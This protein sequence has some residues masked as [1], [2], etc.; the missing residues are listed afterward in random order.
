M[1]FLSGC[2]GSTANTAGKIVSP[3]N[4]LMPIEGKWVIEKGLNSNFTVMGNEV[5]NKWIGKYVQFSH[6]A[7][8]L[9]N[10]LFRQ[11][12]YKI[13]R[14]N[15]DEYLLYRHK[16]PGEKYGIK[17]NKIYVITIAVKNLYSFDAVLTDDG[18]LIIE[19]DDSILYLKKLSDNVDS[20]LINKCNKYNGNNTVGAPAKELPSH[21]GLVLGLKYAGNDNKGELEYKY[22]TI[23]IGAEVKKLHP[24]METPGIFFPRHDGFWRIETK[25]ISAAGRSEDVFYAYSV[26]NGS[27]EE[28]KNIAVNPEKWGE[29]TG[30]IL[31][32]IT[33][34]GNDYIG[35]ESIGEGRYN[36]S[37]NKW[38][39]SRLQMQLV[40]NLP[41]L[42]NVKISDI[43]G[44]SGIRAINNGKTE[45]LGLLNLRKISQSDTVQQDENYSLYR[46]AGHW[47]FKGRVNYEQNM[48]LK[49]SDFNINIIPPTEI[50][51][52]DDL[53]VPWTQIKDKVP[54]A[55]DAYT[56]PNKDIAV[57]VTRDRILVYE[58][59]NQT[60]GEAPIK[61]INLK[62]SETVIMAE[63]ASGNYM[64][65]WEK[66]FMKNAVKEV[67]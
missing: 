48:V 19:F 25:R 14:V 64:S 24:V 41:N 10:D 29:K 15:T 40:D 42:R 49:H 46:K 16:Q 11:P 23:W 50:V 53:C 54:E 31:R 38:N 9:G 26:A 33:Y 65:N 27:S 63:W 28:I 6:D 37:N 61:R 57:I 39:E 35:I 36:S 59:T 7:M 2:T 5:K 34:V 3:Q 32:S 52:Y 12:Q 45:V 43:V 56:S 1:L 8:L 13:K 4:N 58:I 22:R 66:S 47:I 60:L 30:R 17:D 51:F 55:I 44:E 62:N 67:K 18:S 21:T 20:Q